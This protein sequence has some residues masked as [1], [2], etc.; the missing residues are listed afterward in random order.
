MILNW[1]AL[2]QMTSKY[3]IF[4]MMLVT[5]AFVVLVAF[6]SY[7]RNQSYRKRLEY[8]YKHPGS[9]EEAQQLTESDNEEANPHSKQR[10]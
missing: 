4:F 10:S 9:L 1:P 7:Q 6:I 3:I 8:E 5:I 2:A